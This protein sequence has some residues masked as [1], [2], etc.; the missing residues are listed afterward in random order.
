VIAL[1][2]LTIHL[3]GGDATE[4]RLHADGRVETRP[5]KQ[6]WRPGPTLHRDGRVVHGGNEVGRIGAKDGRP[7]PA[8]TKLASGMQWGVE[9]VKG[10][11]L[12]QQADGNAVALARD[13]SMRL[14]V[15]DEHRRKISARPYGRVEGAADHQLART[16]LW[17][18]GLYYGGEVR[19]WH[20]DGTN[21]PAYRLDAE[22]FLV[23]VEQFAAAAET[24]GS[25]CARMGRALAEPARRLRARLNPDELPSSARQ[26]MRDVLVKIG[27]ARKR[28]DLAVQ[29]CLEH[30]DVEPLVGGQIGV[31]IHGGGAPQTR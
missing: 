24:A 19:M 18:V 20:T 16:A 5:A 2:P 21:P 15:R 10:G 27:A 3:A 13:G 1:G 23:A 9:S 25:D 22:A 12:L 29:V 11:V 14:I 17:I 8:E 26:R 31:L 28:A 4:I 6:G 30:P 7:Q